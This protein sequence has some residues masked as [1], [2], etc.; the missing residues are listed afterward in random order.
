MVRMTGLAAG[1][2]SKLTSNGTPMNPELGKA[3]VMA[4]KAP[5]LTLNPLRRAATRA[6]KTITKADR[7]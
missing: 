7:P 3:A 1:W 2:P 5:S 6:S 4:P